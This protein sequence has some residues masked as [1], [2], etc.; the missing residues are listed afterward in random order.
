MVAI[1]PKDIREEKRGAGRAG[2]SRREGWKIGNELKL[3]CGKK[4]LKKRCEVRGSIGIL[5]SQ[6]NR[7]HGEI[8][9]GMESGRKW[10][11]YRP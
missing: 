2:Q 8:V 4:V 9:L 6:K 7:G 3:G 5:L 11:F 1:G 10:G